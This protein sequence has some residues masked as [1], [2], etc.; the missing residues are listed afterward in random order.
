MKWIWLFLF[1]ASGVAHAN[2]PSVAVMPFK[3]LSGSPGALG[4]AIRETVTTDLKEVTGLRVIERANIDRVI[5]EQNLAGQRNDLSPIASVRVGTLLGA[6]LMVTGAY[7]RAA[8]NVRL[9][10]RFVQVE[11]GE[12]LGTAKADGNAADFLRLQDQVT[13]ALLRSVGMAKHAPK[14]VE[15]KRP[16]LKNLKGVE[17]Y[18]QAVVQ[19]DDAKKKELLEKSVAEEPSFTYAARDLDE[20]VKRLKQYDAASERSSRDE[21]QAIKQQIAV[22]KDPAQLLEEYDALFEQLIAKHRYRRL[23]I[24]ARDAFDHPPASPPRKLAETCLR[25]VIDADEHLWDLEATLRD[26]ELFLRRF[27]T[28]KSYKEVREIVDDAIEHRRRCDTKVKK[29]PASLVEAGADPCKIADV[30]DGACHYQE[31]RDLYQRCIKGKEH[32]ADSAVPLMR[33]VWMQIKLND[34]KGAARALEDLK[35]TKTHWGDGMEAALENQGA[36]PFPVED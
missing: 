27:P 32:D 6:T 25:V 33:L 28:S 19:T 12:I 30:H 31:A 2:S 8:D 29:L 22:E 35:A 17:T 24:E 14:F 36:F 13:A 23:Q 9:T 5:A 15:R 18:G 10:A 1:A 16:R 20:L 21:V 3:D 11:T 4:E 34:W 7:Q 26:G